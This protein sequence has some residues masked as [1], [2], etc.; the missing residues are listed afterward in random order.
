[1]KNI[2]GNGYVLL[3]CDRKGVVQTVINNDLEPALTIQVGK[4]LKSAFPG[5][6]KA[7]LEAFFREVNDKRG[8]F[9]WQ[10][11]LDDNEEQTP[12]HLFGGMSLD[13]SIMVFCGSSAVGQNASFFEQLININNEH[14][15]RFREMA[16]SKSGNEISGDGENQSLLEEFTLINNQLV[17]TQRELAKKNQ[18]L[19]HEIEVRKSAEEKLQEAY[20]E[21]ETFSYSVSHD[22]KNPLN[23]IEGFSKFFM[24]KYSDKLDEQG[25]LFITKIIESGEKMKGLIGSLLTFSLV[26]KNEVQKTSV[27]LVM[28]ARNIIQDLSKNDSERIIEFDL[29]QQLIAECDKSLITIVLDNLLNNAWKY[30]SKRSNAIIKMGA[31][32]TGD[33]TVYFINDNGAGFDSKSATNLFVPFQRFHSGHEFEGSGIGLSTV[34]RIIQRHDGNIWAKS[35]PGEGATFYFTLGK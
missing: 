31:N 5:S 17:S 24:L 1:M 3:I 22:L 30:T 34:R 6:L 9:D 13:D 14:V 35:K 15:N 11:K 16:K 28:I 33:G 4:E 23:H 26:L 25:Q 27:D 21:L 7:E 19:I 2:I 12:L 32:E 8:A 29:P 10:I 20:K 18:E